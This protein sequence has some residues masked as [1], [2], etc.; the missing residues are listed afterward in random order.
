[1]SAHLK[2]KLIRG[3]N[4]E[5]LPNSYPA[6]GHE[7]EEDLEQYVAFYPMSYRV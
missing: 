6:E 2:E 5:L 3:R 4:I 7:S 1:M